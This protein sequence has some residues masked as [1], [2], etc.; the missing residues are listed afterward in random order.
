MNRE[1]RLSPCKVAQYL[2]AAGASLSSQ[3]KAGQ[4]PLQVRRRRRR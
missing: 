1:R 2:I 3:T 4:T